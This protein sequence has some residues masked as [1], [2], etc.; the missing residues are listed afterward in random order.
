M[1]R[2]FLRDELG[3]SASEYALIIGAFG[4]TMV[5]GN[6][7]LGAAVDTEMSRQADAISDNSTSTPTPSPTPTSTPTPTPTPTS[8]PTPTPTPTSTPTPTPAPT[9]TPTCTPRGQSGNCN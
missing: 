3:N 7:V 2:H 8:T 6:M 4:L 9:P 1:I 5:L